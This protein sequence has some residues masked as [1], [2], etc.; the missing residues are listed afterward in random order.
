MTGR[1]TRANRRKIENKTHQK[2]DLDN[3]SKLNV[4]EL[5]SDKDQVS[6]TE[7]SSKVAKETKETVAQ[8]DDS[9]LS[10][11]EQEDEELSSEDEQDSS[12]EDDEDLDELLNKAQAAIASQ[13]ASIQLEKESDQDIINRKLSQMNTGISIDKELYLK[14]VSGR[15]KL[16]PDAVALVSP[17]EKVTEKASVVL[18]AN[19][20]ED[21]KL[22]K[23][24]RQAVSYINLIFNR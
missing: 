18:T 7:N 22:N 9:S 10:E 14:T 1:L 4:K 16:T 23:K 8:K 15:A 11:Q 2:I 5:V 12:S 13:A 21:K 3:L 6:L 24:E 20:D 19:K 17:G